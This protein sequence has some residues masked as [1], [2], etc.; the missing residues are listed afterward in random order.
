[1]HWESVKVLSKVSRAR[2]PQ[3]GN[4]VKLKE[5]AVS[6]SL[7]L[8][9]AHPLPCSQVPPCVSLTAASAAIAGELMR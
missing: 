3:P 6:S 8:P 5:D 1:M 4:Q 7:R 9:T 2:A